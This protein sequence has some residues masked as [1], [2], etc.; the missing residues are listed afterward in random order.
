MIRVLTSHPFAT[1]SPDFETPE[2]AVKDDTHCPAFIHRTEQ[3]FGGPLTVLDL[4]CAQGG[5]V[6]DFR[7]RGHIA[8]GI[9]GVAKAQEHVF[10]A[11][12]TEPYT[13]WEGFKPLRF[14]LIMAWDV[15]EH[16]PAERIGRTLGLI[17][18]HL[19]WNGLFVASIPIFVAPPWHVT[20]EEQPWWEE[21]YRASG[22]HPIQSPYA[23]DEYPR[24]SGNQQVA[25]RDW[26]ARAGLGFHLAARTYI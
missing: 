10:N 4:G 23:I 15:L 3:A 6:Q 14:D 21:R 2:G 13:I 11:D 16:I 22:L 9:D 26:D 8:I 7:N 20:L 12:I 5:L 19:R 18:F 25:V 1:W 17:A 24:G